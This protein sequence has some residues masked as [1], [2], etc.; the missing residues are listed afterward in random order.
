[1]FSCFKSKNVLSIAG[2]VVLLAIAGCKSSKPD[3]G[4]METRPVLPATPSNPPTVVE[5]I[6]PPVSRP[7]PAADASDN[8]AT[9]ILAWDGVIKHYQAGAGETNAPFTFSLTN[10]SPERLIIYDTSTTCDCTVAQLPAKPWLLE[11]GAGGLI[12]AT[13]D[14]RNRTTGATNFVIVFT[15]KGNRLLT[16]TA[17]LPTP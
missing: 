7:R 6:I 10:V 8:M 5:S 17:S 12:R 1:M 2:V 13:L 11:S 3:I 15:S 16:V 4:R 14:L 9:N